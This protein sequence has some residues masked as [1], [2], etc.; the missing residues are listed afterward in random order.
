MR[1]RLALEKCAWPALWGY[2]LWALEVTSGAFT[3][4]LRHLY[5]CNDRC[6]NSSLHFCAVQIRTLSNQRFYKK[7]QCTA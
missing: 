4:E 5:M 2:R 6:H 7:G 1:T 3:L